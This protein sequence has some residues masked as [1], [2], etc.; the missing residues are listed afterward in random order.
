M[1]FPPYGQPTDLEIIM[2]RLPK[3]NLDRLF[4]RNHMETN[5][6]G[7]WNSLIVSPETVIDKIKPGMNIFLGTAAAEPRTMVRYLM[8]DKGKQLEDLELI[9]LVSFGDVIS[10]KALHSRRYRLKTFFSDGW[11]TMPSKRGGWI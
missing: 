2:R 3:N 5:E 9:Q 10:P 1:G 6:S 11:R 4:N 7:Q 8:T